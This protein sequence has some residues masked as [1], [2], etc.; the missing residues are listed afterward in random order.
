MPLQNRSWSAI[1][2]DASMII[3][4]ASF[5]PMFAEDGV[6]FRTKML[7][8]IQREFAD[9]VELDLREIQRDTDPGFHHTR[10]SQ[11]RIRQRVGS[12]PSP[13]REA[14][15]NPADGIRKFQLQK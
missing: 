12:P 8:Y 13:A 5:D 14:Q 15:F 6:P 9:V 10:S 4:T 3:P 2:K 7:R 11:P 1:A